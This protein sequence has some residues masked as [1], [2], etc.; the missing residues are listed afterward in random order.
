LIMGYVPQYECARGET[1]A[2]FGVGTPLEL[3]ATS[4]R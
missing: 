1:E 4:G 3:I 2:F